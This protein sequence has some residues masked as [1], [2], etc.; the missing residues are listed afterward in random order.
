[1]KYYA[2]ATD[3][4]RNEP[5]GIV[6]KD[7]RHSICHGLHAA[8]HAW[9]N[10]YNSGGTKTPFEGLPADIELSPYGPLGFDVD[11]VLDQESAT[12]PTPQSPALVD[13]VWEPNRSPESV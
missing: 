3:T 7:G 4:V 2:V 9:A 8:G 6:V 12:I 10:L 11:D 5:F 13:S 1:M